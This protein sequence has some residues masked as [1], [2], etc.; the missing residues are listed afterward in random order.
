MIERGCVLKPVKHWRNCCSDC[1]GGFK[2]CT[3]LLGELRRLDQT[4]EDRS[5]G[6]RT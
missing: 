1:G 4:E 5:W 6:N 3:K 2:G